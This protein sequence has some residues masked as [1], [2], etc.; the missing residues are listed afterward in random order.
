MVSGPN[1]APAKDKRTS[2]LHQWEKATSRGCRPLH[3]A[4]R[5]RRYLEVVDALWTG[6]VT[7]MPNH[8]SEIFLKL[9]SASSCFMAS[10]IALANFGLPFWNGIAE[11]VP[12]SS[13]APW[14]NGNCELLSR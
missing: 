14:R 2:E 9:P 5:V 11:G 1:G 7:S 6:L 4:G 3:C 10:S 12:P 13:V 8:F